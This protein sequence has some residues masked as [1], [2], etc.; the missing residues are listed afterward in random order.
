V[1]HD[2]RP[3]YEAAVRDGSL[4]LFGLSE[5]GLGPVTVTRPDRAAATREAGDAGSS[6]VV[7][8]AD[9]YE[10]GYRFGHAWLL[11][12]EGREWQLGTG[13]RSGTVVPA[14]RRLANDRGR[15]YLRGFYDA[16]MRKP[17][18]PVSPRSRRARP[19]TVTVT[20]STDEYATL[21]SL[22]MADGVP[23]ATRIR[24]MILTYAADDDIRKRVDG[25]LPAKRSWPSGE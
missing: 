13:E 20:L 5:G 21:K 9:E 16:V 17:A 4:F 10:S 14:L 24:A 22:Q 6:R 19:I 7:P 23:T 1:S 18:E 8:T 12:D 25:E 3:G 11:T 2:L 15:E